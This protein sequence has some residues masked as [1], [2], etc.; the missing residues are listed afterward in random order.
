MILKYLSKRIEAHK[1]IQVKSIEC[2]KYSLWWNKL[3]LGEYPPL[4]TPITSYIWNYFNSPKKKKNLKDP[5]KLVKKKL[6][7]VN[8]SKKNKI[9]ESSEKI[10]F[11]YVCRNSMVPTGIHQFEST[12]NTSDKNLWS[13]VNHSHKN[14]ETQRLREIKLFQQMALRL[15]ANINKVNSL[16]DA[17]DLP[18]CHLNPNGGYYNGLQSKILKVNET[19]KNSSSS[20]SFN[21]LKNSIKTKKNCFKLKFS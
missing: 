4:N 15:T 9:N 16:A 5:N 17:Y 20:S 12:I 10:D 13:H 19:K 6:D 21:K 1:I 8:I 18:I 11:K 7:V 2:S 14:Q 3:I